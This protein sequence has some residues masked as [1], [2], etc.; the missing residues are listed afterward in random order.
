MSSFHGA[1]PTRIRHWIQGLV[2]GTC[3]AP[4]GSVNQQYTIAL[5]SFLYHLAAFEE[6]VPAGKCSPRIPAMIFSVIRMAVTG[7]LC[8]LYVKS[9]Y[10][11]ISGGN[12]TNATSMSTSGIL[13]SMLQLIAW[14]VSRNDCLSYVTRAVRVTDQ[15]LT[16]AATNRQLVVRRLVDRLG[17][18]VDLVLKSQPVSSKCFI[19]AHT[20]R[21]FVIN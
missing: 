15:I 2:E 8:Y 3:D 1:L 14:H 17:F 19:C 16:S 9:F 13:D 12:Q 11:F 10:A 20:V 4:G 7:R 5:L 18:E 6:N 21:I